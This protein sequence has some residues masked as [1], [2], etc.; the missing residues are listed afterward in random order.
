VSYIKKRS[1]FDNHREMVSYTSQIS[2]CSKEFSK[3]K[4]MAGREG[5][6]QDVFKESDSPVA[7]KNEETPKLRMVARTRIDSAT[8]R[9]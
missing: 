7:K 9:E 5:Y 8:R 1:D 2:C 3:I 6:C 4:C